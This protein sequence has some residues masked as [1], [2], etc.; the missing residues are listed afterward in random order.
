MG[1]RFKAPSTRHRFNSTPVDPEREVREMAAS[2]HTQEQLDHV[3]DRVRDGMR[4]AVFQKLW[5][6]LGNPD[7][8]D[9]LAPLEGNGHAD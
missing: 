7:L 9:K 3:L 1:H 4:N 5:P 8:I 6:Y 2:I